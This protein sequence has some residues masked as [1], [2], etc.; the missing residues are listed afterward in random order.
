MW[1]SVGNDRWTLDDNSRHLLLKAGS[2]YIELHDHTV[3]VYG[4]PGTVTDARFPLGAPESPDRAVW[5][6]THS[7]D[8][9]PDGNN[10][11]VW[12]ALARYGR[13]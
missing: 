9:I 7:A 4:G 12:A 10:E 1:V 5:K 11:P 8:G 3:H 13:E 6:A 2:R